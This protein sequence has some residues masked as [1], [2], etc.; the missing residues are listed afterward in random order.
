MAFRHEK[1]SDLFLMETSV[2]NMFINEYMAT[3]P[4]DFV[5][6]YLIARMYEAADL[7]VTNEDIAK[8]LGIELEDVLK[9]WTYWDKKGVIRKI[10]PE[11][12]S[13]LEYDVEFIN[14]R[15]QLYG[16]K[17]VK[18]SREQSF[19]ESMA[20]TEIQD[21]LAEIEKM[22]GSVMNGT[23]VTEIVSWLTDY[24]VSPEVIIYGYRYSLD[25]KKKNIKYIEA[26]IRSW[27]E[28]GLTTVEEITKK[29]GE[30]ERNII[31]TSGSSRRWDST[32]IPQRKSAGSWIR[33]SRPWGSPSRKCWRHAARRQAS[34]AR[35]STMS[36]KCFQTG[37]RNSR[38]LS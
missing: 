37:T 12:G 5:K 26:V 11:G 16:S 2:E 9:A 34:Q 23:E 29:L 33:G 35:T 31:S 22:T 32:G 38:E 1:T 4:G 8:S 3:A 14:L 28:E 30:N 20:D 24:N 27:S 25:R 6:V 10:I 36:T 18:V 17:A 15:E 21:M 13:K 19:Q 7:E